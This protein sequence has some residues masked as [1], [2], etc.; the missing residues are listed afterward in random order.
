[1]HLVIGASGYAGRH[2]VAAVGQHEPVRTAEPGDDL[3]AAMEGVDTV[4]V[5]AERH[6]PLERLRWRK[7]PDPLLLDLVRAARDAE[8]RR[9]VLVSTSFVFGAAHQG[10]LTET[11]RPRPEHPYEKLM[12]R[13]EAWLRS[14]DDLEVVVLRPAQ[15][16]GAGEPLVT[17]LL[18]RL[19]TGRL[20]LPDGGRARRSFLAG[21]DLGRACWAAAR[22]GSPGA[23]YLLSG[24]EASWHELLVAAAGSVGLTPQLVWLSYDYAYL[25]S[26]ARR[27]TA[28]PGQ[29]C[30]PTPL[31]VDAI[32]RPHVVEDG[33]SRR[34]LSWRPEVTGFEQGMVEIT[35]W[36]RDAVGS[37]SR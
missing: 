21:T 15:G 3:R 20:L 27:W 12:A 18:R 9:L 2:T 11:S 16:F 36:F 7:E 24:F 14:Q 8:V 25:A 22:R 33:W 28:P 1:M 23:A 19:A 10:R 37:A 26:A 29:E 35:A 13:D 31:V 17:C 6:S 5:A 4:H 32:A 34:E 30:W